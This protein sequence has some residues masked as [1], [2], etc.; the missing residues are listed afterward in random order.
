MSVDQSGHSSCSRSKVL[1]VEVIGV[2]PAPY[3]VCALAPVHDARGPAAARPPHSPL[4]L[5]V[6]VVVVVKEIRRD[7]RKLN[8]WGVFEKSEIFEYPLFGLLQVV[9][10]VLVDDRPAGRQQQL[11]RG[12]EVLVKVVCRYLVVHVV[13]VTEDH[14]RLISPA[15]SDVPYGV[16]AAAQHQQRDV[17]R[18]AV[19]DTRSVALDRQIELAQTVT[20]E[21]VSAAL[22][23][24]CARPVDFDALVHD[25]AEKGQEGLVVDAV[26]QRHVH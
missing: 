3:S 1:R 23:D 8:A 19:L 21:R 18:L 24:D 15:P 4:H 12:V 7:V 2:V 10:G 9:F 13:L 5:F 17:E 26:L 6:L 25:G 14:T 20:V 22:E 16:S 11:V